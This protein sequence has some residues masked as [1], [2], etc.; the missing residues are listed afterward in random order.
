[1]CVPIAE[2]FIFDTTNKSAETR[3]S[4]DMFWK[5]G[6][7]KSE[8]EMTLMESLQSDVLTDDISD[9]GTEA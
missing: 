7:R 6:I 8:S 1:M 9:T 4:M 2:L 5:G 3:K